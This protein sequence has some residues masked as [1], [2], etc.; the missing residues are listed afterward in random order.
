MNEPAIRSLNIA[1]YRGLGG[2]KLEGFGRINLLVGANNAGK[3]SVLEA[4]ALFARPLDI[5]NWVD[6]AWRREIKGTRIPIAETLKWMFPRTPGSPE[7]TGRIWINGTGAFSGRRLLAQYSEEKVIPAP[8]E[9]SVPE[10]SGTS[11]MLDLSAD[12]ERTLSDGIPREY[13]DSREVVVG[14]DDSMT[15]SGTI[16]GP[17]LPLAVVDAS[18]HRVESTVQDIYSQAL[19]AERSDQDFKADFIRV[20]QKIDPG[21]QRLDLVQTGRVS[22]RLQ[23]KHARTGVTPVTAF[24]DGF[25][26]ALMIAVT[27]PTVRN[28]VLL[29]DELETGLHVTALDSVLGLLEWAAKEFNV[30]VFATTHSLEAV[31]AVIR[32]F[33]HNPETLVAYRIEREPNLVAR[34]FDRAAL[35]DLRQVLGQEIR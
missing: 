30:Q 28:G 1:E 3:T 24:G 20:L 2:L 14:Q 7:D 11:F 17:L 5:D 9:G 21:V 16:P 33:E 27:I 12:S 31:D 23:I 19:R 15:Y 25:R 18:A 8:S 26:R 10:K 35:H 13:Q 22:T 32:A 34:R 29:I 4:L 6:T